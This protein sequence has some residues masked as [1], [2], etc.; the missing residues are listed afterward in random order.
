MAELIAIEIGGELVKVPAWATEETQKQIL[1]A[2]SGNSKA[3]KQQAKDFETLLDLQRKAM[4]GDKKAQQRLEEELK[5]NREDSKKSRVSFLQGVENLFMKVG[6]TRGG[7][8][9][10]LGKTTLALTAV[11]S[12]VTIARFNQL[13]SAL[14][15]LTKTGLGFGDA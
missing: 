6:G 10:L 11:I 14:N 8:F 7:V 13:G 1:A 2:L 5:K 3:D 15:D 12:G 9:G 4:S